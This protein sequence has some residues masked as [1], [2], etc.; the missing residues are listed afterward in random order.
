[1]MN[2]ETDKELIV[3][4]IAGDKQ[5]LGILFNRYY[6]DI[7]NVLYQRVSDKVLIA[8]FIQDSFVKLWEKRDSI[9]PKKSVKNFIFRI[10]INLVLDH[11]K[12]ESQKEKHQDVIMTM[13]D[14]D[15][16]KDSPFMESVY[17][18][19]SKLPSDLST[20]FFLSK[21]GEFSYNDIAEILNISVKTV[22]SR[23]S[24][25]LKICREKIK[26]KIE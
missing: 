5:V 22:E 23:I 25:V 24:K 7:Y 12:H 6:K 11:Y 26:Y 16:I 17:N 9:D 19:V 3:K 4:L 21:F 20:T 18:L 1:M 14:D 15:E 8:D 13:Y 10:A 2:Q